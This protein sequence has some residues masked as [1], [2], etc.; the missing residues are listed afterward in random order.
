MLSVIDYLKQKEIALGLGVTIAGGAVAA[1][2]PEPAKKYVSLIPAGG[3]L[4]TIYHVYKFKEQGGIPKPGENIPPDVLTRHYYPQTALFA[5]LID[6]VRRTY[7]FYLTYKETKQFEKGG[8]HFHCLAEDF[9]FLKEY[10]VPSGVS[11]KYGEATYGEKNWFWI[12]FY[13]VPYYP[14]Y[15]EGVAVTWKMNKSR[16]AV[17]PKVYWRAWT[18]LPPLEG[19]PLKECVD[20]KDRWKDPYQGECSPKCV[21]SFIACDAYVARV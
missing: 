4:Y 7:R 3:L 16:T 2:T 21:A 18:P 12:E 20:Y 17:F 19:K 13:G 5:K 9:T 8:L 1:V 14:E 15:P 11:V 6:R 10:T